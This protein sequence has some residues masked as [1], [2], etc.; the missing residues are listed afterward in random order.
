MKQAGTT[1]LVIS[2][3]VGRFIAP[4]TFA[5]LDPSDHSAVGSMRSTNVRRVP[6]GSVPTGRN[7]RADPALSA[8]PPPAA[9]ARSRLRAPARTCRPC[10]AVEGGSPSSASVGIRQQRERCGAS[11]LSASLCPAFTCWH[12]LARLSN[13]IAICRWRQPDRPRVHPCNGRVQSTP[14]ILTL[15]VAVNDGATPFLEIELAGL[16]LGV[17]TS[18]LTL[19]P[20]LRATTSTFRHVGDVL[21]RAKSLSDVVHSAARGR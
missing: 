8:A 15:G 19:A 5:R 1:I 6:T 9:G 3:A 11:P 17:G 21:D 2:A 20:Q 10:I 14:A 13:S 12:T 7:A 4:F 18:S 16:R